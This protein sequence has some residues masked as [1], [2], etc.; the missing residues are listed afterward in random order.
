MKSL[1]VGIWILS[2]TCACPVV[3][4]GVVVF[5]LFKVLFFVLVIIIYISVLVMWQVM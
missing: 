4:V 1:V 3:F 2:G 5:V